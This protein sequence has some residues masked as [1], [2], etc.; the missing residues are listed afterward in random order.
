MSESETPF[1]RPRFPIITAVL[2]V[3]SLAGFMVELR[4]GPGLADFLNRHSFVP[5]QTLAY[6]DGAAGT[7][8]GRS[9]LP[10]FL[11]LF[12]HAGFLHLVINTSYLWMVGDVMEVF[13]GPVRFVVLWLAGALVW[14]AVVLVTIPSP[15]SGLPCL[16]TGGTIAIL[17]GAYLG[18]YRHLLKT[19]YRGSR[20][21]LVAIGTP[22]AVVALGWFPLQ[23]LTRYTPIAQSLDTEYG[24]PWWAIVTSFVLGLVL[25]QFLLPTAP[26]GAEAVAKPVLPAENVEAVEPGVVAGCCRTDGGEAS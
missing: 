6:L 3:G 1:P 16:G 24:P 25:V 8:F 12:F 11:T 2:L 22:T 10:F 21:K 20:W 4:Q 5:E 17:L 15:A 14:A 19:V 23:L 26:T 9:V 7:N 13:L 18:I